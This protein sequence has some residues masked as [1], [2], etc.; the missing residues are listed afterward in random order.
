MR[1]P[2]KISILAATLFFTACTA[3]QNRD[4]VIKKNIK[5]VDYTAERSGALNTPKKRVMVLPLLDSISDRVSEDQ[6]EQIRRGFIEQL[7]KS[8]HFIPFDSSDLKIDL[9]TQIKDGQYD[10]KALSPKIDDLGIGFVL[11]AKVLEVKLKKKSDPVGVIRKL[12]STFEVI[13]KVRILNTRSGR[14][15]FNTVKTITHEQDDVR[16]AKRLQSDRDFVANP[17]LIAILIKDSLFDYIPTLETS[18]VEVS[19]EGRIAAI[20]GE[21]IYL[22]VGKISG[23]QIGDLLKVSESSQEIYDA[24]MGYALGKAPGKLKGTLEVVSYFGY[25]GAVA[26]VHSGAGFKENDR[27]EIYQ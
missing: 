3:F 19:W 24:E 6:R 27:V 23:L 11:E 4:P 16:V 5:D 8:G 7:N 9:K 2:I 13:T 15:V 1:T 26:I 18:M 20:Q 12:S 10:L 14:E 17:E 25:D 22:N 21:K